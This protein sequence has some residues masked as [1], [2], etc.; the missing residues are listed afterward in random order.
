MNK[1]L[2]L[3]VAVITLSACE[4]GPINRISPEEAAR[5]WGADLGFKVT[6]VNCTGVDTDNDGYVSCTLSH[7]GRE[8]SERRTKS[9]QCA[10]YEA[11]RWNSYAVGCK[12]TA[13]KVGTRQRDEGSYSE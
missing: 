9:L 8:P 6:G 1:L 2:S 3:I 11:G 4:M 12:E 10:A 5:K 13:A 7:E